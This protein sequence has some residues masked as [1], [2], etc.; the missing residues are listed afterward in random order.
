VARSRENSSTADEEI[1][2]V[3]DAT[4]LNLAGKLAV[5]MGEMQG[6][7][8]EKNP[9]FN[10]KYV[11]AKNLADELRPRLAAARIFLLP[12]VIGH[13]RFEARTARGGTTYLTT[14]TVNF[15]FIDGATG[16]TLEGIGI[17]YGDDAGDKGANKAFTGALKFFLIEAFLVGG[18]DPE[19]D[20]KTDERADERASRPLPELNIGPSAVTGIAR[21]GRAS[22][23]TRPQIVRISELSAQ[24]ALGPHGLAGELSDLGYAVP[25]LDD[26]EKKAR[27]QV[28]A[29]LQTLSGEDAGTLVRELE[30]QVEI[31]SEQNEILEDLN[32]LDLAAVEVEEGGYGS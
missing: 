30:M 8:R 7:E 19:S 11:P 10:Y 1:R 26:D 16:E 24:L 18:E 6:I 22:F 3:K 25:A 12:S 32:Q 15:R 13:E 9:H 5:I 14:L 31:Q 20:K 21:G 4:T 28:L 27:A 23:A 29:V 17:G 2:P